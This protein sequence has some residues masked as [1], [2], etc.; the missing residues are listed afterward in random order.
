M[1]QIDTM[2]VNAI[3]VLAADA[4]QKA[5]SGHP[6]LPLGSAAM[7]YELWA[8]HMNHNPKNPQWKNRDRFILSGGHGSTLLYSLLHLFGYGLTKEDM[9]NFRQMD[10]LTPG[11]PEYGHTVGVEATTGPL[12][13][14]MG[15]AVGMAMAE[16]HLA[17][18]FNKD[19]YPV[20]DHYTY[21]LGGD[22]CMMEGISSEAFSLA[23]TLGLSKL[24]VFYDS[25]K[26]SI[27][28]STDIAFTE[29]V[30][31]RMEAFGF[32]LLTVEDGNDLDAIGK[33]IE[34]AKA[35][36]TRPSF[37]TV[38]TQIGYGCPAKQ[39]K[40]SAH[41]EPLGEDNVTAMK[42]NLN[43]P[44][45][46]PFYVP[47]EVYANYKAHAEKGA[48]AEAEWNA[49]FDEYCRKYPEMKDMWDKFHNPELAKAAYD[50][51]EY[52]AYD[53][54]PDATRSLSGKQLQKLKNLMPN[55]IGGAADLA[56]S[57]K[58]YMSDMG[59]F[60]KDNY[61]GRN[62]HFGVRELAMAAIG[63]GLMLHGG[64]RAFVS[65][66]FVFSDY[67]KPMARLSA[68]M[69]VPLTFVFTHDS[70]GVG[71]DGP[72]HEP[73]EQLAMLR[74]MPN[75]HVFRPADATETAAA[76]YSAVSSQKTPTALVLTRQNL[77]QLAGSSKEALKGAYILEDS[78]KEVPD[79]IIIATGS[80]VALAVGAKAE[81]AKEG[82]DVRVVSM[83]CMDIFEE[84]S[85]EYKEKVLPKAVRKR[86]AVEALGDF[87]W[88]RYVGLDGA[89][90]TM[91]G[92]GASAPAGL[93]FKKFG[94]TVENVVEAVKSL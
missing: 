67:T 24:I 54:K 74:S 8:N 32:Q 41:G 27:E 11:H 90:V 85:E 78:S 61:A 14:G 60:S 68:L 15:M 28:G 45:M 94:F 73:I 51:E 50:C 46:E 31:K 2:S 9:M 79:A 58:T 42:E 5:K 44:S 92:F 89:A 55:L 10:S 26:I 70:I 18:V 43:W 66:F 69:G 72:T 20:V 56:P 7:A 64:L 77:P 6:G 59:D 88:G 22:G 81:L 84:Q 29:N 39:G 80:E 75:F 91:K 49:L 1:N 19:G 48:K 25:N 35:D 82:M 37:I 34:E 13:A 17:A 86:V 38:K 62:L 16:S 4:V 65:T 57:T 12:G 83:P 47:D 21:V 40:A 87:G 63:N 23:G 93:L 33:A 71:E 3:R 30:Q 36:T 53:E 52:W 76:W